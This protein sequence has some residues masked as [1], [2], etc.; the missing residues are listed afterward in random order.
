MNARTQD[1]TRELVSSRWSDRTDGLGGGGWPAGG[2]Y[3]SDTW[4]LDLSTM[5]WSQA[6]APPPAGKQPSSPSAE[7]LPPS[8]SG[9]PSGGT[10]PP[11][12]PPPPLGN[13]PTAGHTLIPW[14][15][16]LLS[17]GGHIK[18]HYMAHFVFSDVDDAALERIQPVCR[19]AWCTALL[20]PTVNGSMSG[21]TPGSTHFW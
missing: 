9:P 4:A 14:Q 6:A 13:P 17:I 16:S 12:P 10:R 20:P 2:R 7:P 21:M 8:S 1:C 3:L 11:P 19:I 18:V 15:G 5:T